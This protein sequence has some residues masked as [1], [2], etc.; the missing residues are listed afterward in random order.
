ML[1]VEE[2]AKPIKSLR[3]FDM[4]FFTICAFVG[5]DTL[6]H[7]WGVTKGTFEALTLGT[8][9]A[10]VAIGLIGYAFG[11]AVRAKEAGI[12]LEVELDA[13]PA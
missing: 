13:A 9:A 7:T 10:I 1:A 12:P 6:G 11:G 4:V 3:P 5:R 2:K 8:L